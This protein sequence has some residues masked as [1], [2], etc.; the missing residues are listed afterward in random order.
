VAT[1]PFLI[2]LHHL[3]IIVSS[4]N[5]NQ[6]KT[7]WLALNKIAYCRYSSTWLKFIFKISIYGRKMTSIIINKNFCNILMYTSSVNYW[8]ES[9][10]MNWYITYNPIS[11]KWTCH[12]HDD[13]ENKFKRKNEGYSQHEQALIISF[14]SFI[15][16]WVFHISII[17]L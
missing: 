13:G 11:Q 12:N 7:I 15:N 5:L 17:P 16:F 1:A 2:R 3:L 9:N 10:C 4:L 6:M 8:L 14:L